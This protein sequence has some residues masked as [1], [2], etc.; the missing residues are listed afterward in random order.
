M[1]TITSSCA[2]GLTVATFAQLPPVTVTFCGVAF[3]PTRTWN[4]APGPCL[5]SVVTPG[6]TATARA[7]SGGSSTLVTGP[8][9]DAARSHA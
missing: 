9:G 6:V 8:V 4:A 2:A 1:L 7:T 5:Q 3:T